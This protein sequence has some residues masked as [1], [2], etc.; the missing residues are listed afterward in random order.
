MNNNVKDCDFVAEI[1]LMTQEHEIFE[2][3]PQ[4]IRFA[5][6]HLKSCEKCRDFL[7]YLV[8]QRIKAG[9]AG[10]DIDVRAG[11]VKDSHTS[12]PSRFHPLGGH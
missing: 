8:V 7:K 9:I 3:D 12:M 1:F 4:D 5:E 2:V 6:D 11:T 10:F